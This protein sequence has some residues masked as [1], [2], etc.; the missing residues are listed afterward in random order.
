MVLGP[1]YVLFCTFLVIKTVQRDIRPSTAG[2]S[3]DRYDA[4][5]TEDYD[6][7]RESDLSLV[8][9]DFAS[10]SGMG[11][12]RLSE[13]QRQPARDL[14]SPTVRSPRNVRTSEATDTST[15]QKRPKFVQYIVAATRSLYVYRR[16]VFLIL[17][18]VIALCA[19]MV[20]AGTAIKIDRYSQ[21]SF[22]VSNL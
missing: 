1:M 18:S 11:E 19:A 5:S 15:T 9:V 7:H 2:V 22:Y 21:D 20:F 14:P 3:T 13:F 6:S 10:E 16:I 12:V 17:S 4:R 8:S